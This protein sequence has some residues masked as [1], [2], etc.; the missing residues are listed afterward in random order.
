MKKIICLVTMASLMLAGCSTNNGPKTTQGVGHGYGGDIKVELVTEGKEIKDIKV[1]SNEE[2]SVVFNR[3]LPIL[4]ERIV[5]AQS[6]EVDSVSGATFTSFGV[7]AAV[8]EAMKEAGMGEY[9]ISFDTKGPEVEKK[10]LEEVKTQLVVVGGG[11]AGLSA[12]IEAKQNGVEDIIVIE[13]LD[14]LS[15]NGKFDLDFVDLINS[16]AQKANG[17]ED[18]V[19]DFVKYLKETKKAWDT[20][21][22]IL[23]QAEGS[24]E[25]DAWLRDMGINLNYNFDTRN[26]MTEWDAYAGEHI[27]EKMEE[28]INRLGIEVRTGT[29]GLDLIMED[30]KAI[31]VKAES[32]EGTY[33]IKADAVIVATGGFSSNK[34]LLAKYAPGTE[35]LQTSNQMGTTGDFIPVFEK[36]DIALDNM[37][38]TRVFPFINIPRRDLTGGPDGFILVNKDGE[39]FI[40]ETKREMTMA[41]AI[42]EQ[43][44]GKV[45]Y[46]YDQ[47]LYD[48]T[49]RLQKHTKLGYHTKAETLDEL[50]E[51][52]GID[53]ENL[54]ATVKT[55]N[56]A[57]EGKIED[58][59]R[60][61]AFTN[62]INENG[63]YYGVQVESAIH[64]TRGGVVAN[65]KAE[66]L[67]NDNEVVE[68][69]YAAGEVTSSSQAYS[70]AVV[71]GRISGEEAAKHILNK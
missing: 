14:I 59:F 50:A 6:P 15:G 4:V 62:T 44:D 35:T 34:E 56:E 60:E 70:A 38:I 42:Q 46:I 41:T 16:E 67:N 1:L 2:T 8:A 55:F 65:E 12:A 17:I 21:E 66:V 30:G 43:P 57:V 49:Y 53:A 58:P 27:Q 22:R 37:D 36:N 28:E 5:E 45:F 7:K 19:E 23:A 20:D 71:F 32:K 68:G 51:K 63:P 18:T 54:K 9:K 3:A 40:D 13:K 64:M 48:N 33:D 26:H 61:K 69:L 29:K 25:L 24:Y 52:L 10:E 11:P 47:D 39:R 31:G